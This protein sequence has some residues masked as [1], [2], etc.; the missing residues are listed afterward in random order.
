MT[1]PCKTH[2]EHMRWKHSESS[3]IRIQ[4]DNTYTH[5]EIHT[6]MSQCPYSI[7]TP[8]ALL[9]FRLWIER[10]NETHV[11]VCVF[12]HK[13]RFGIEIENKKVK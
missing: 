13:N 5:A 4:T 8:Y 3:H 1:P 2:E 6:A 11:S 12:A 7:Y 9:L 10:M